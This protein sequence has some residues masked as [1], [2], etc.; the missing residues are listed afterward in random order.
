MLL[1]QALIA[2]MPRASLALDLF[3]NSTQRTAKQCD[4]HSPTVATSHCETAACMS[5]YRSERCCITKNVGQQS[6]ASHCI[7][8]A[9]VKSNIDCRLKTGLRAAAGRRLPSVWCAIRRPA[10]VLFT[11]LCRIKGTFPQHTLSGCQ[12]PR[13]LEGVSNISG[14]AHCFTVCIATESEAVH[15]RLRQ[16][17]DRYHKNLSHLTCRG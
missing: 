7:W 9:T 14:Q 4:F 5:R 8:N 13:S 16:C 1:Q 6:I 15:S 10:F 2:T 11:W 17:E 3:P 12:S